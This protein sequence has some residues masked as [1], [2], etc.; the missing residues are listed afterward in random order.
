MWSKSR[1]K[2]A[3]GEMVDFGIGLLLKELEDRG[4]L[5]ADGYFKAIWR[6]FIY[7]S[8]SMRQTGNATKSQ[9]PQPSIKDFRPLV[10]F[11][12][13]SKAQSGLKECFGFCMV[14]SAVTITK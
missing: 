3:S 6:W 13:F 1:R 11:V 8:T 7:L 10:S 2:L 4:L 5:N 12:L 9:S 14:P